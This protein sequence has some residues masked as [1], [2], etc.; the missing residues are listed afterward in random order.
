M[1][2][3]FEKENYELRFDDAKSQLYDAQRTIDDLIDYIKDSKR[4]NRNKIL[5]YALELQNAIENGIDV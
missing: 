1:L 5:D 3:K 2:F 4:I